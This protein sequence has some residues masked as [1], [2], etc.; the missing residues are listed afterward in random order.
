MLRHAAP[1]PLSLIYIAHRKRSPSPHLSL[2]VTHTYPPPP[3]THIPPSPPPPHTHTSAHACKLQRDT[4]IHGQT[5]MLESTESQVISTDVLKA[6]V[7]PT[8]IADIWRKKKHPTSAQVVLHF[9]MHA[10]PKLL[11]HQW[12]ELLHQHLTL[13][14]AK[15]YQ[16]PVNISCICFNCI[17]VQLHVLGCRL[18]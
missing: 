12:D 18:T 1:L 13:A 4:F 6:S 2:S 10:Q 9:L 11:K 7:H 16:A 15:N 3:H 14:H 8:V 5:L 17:D